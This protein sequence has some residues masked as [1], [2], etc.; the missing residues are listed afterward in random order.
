MR[1][2]LAV[3]LRRSSRDLEGIEEVG[4]QSGVRIG[5]EQSLWDRLA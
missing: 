5:G 2:G 4:L 3:P 1:K